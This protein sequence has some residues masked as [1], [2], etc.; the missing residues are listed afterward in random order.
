VE[1]VLLTLGEHGARAITASESIVQPGF[2]VDALDTTG[3]GDAFCAAVTRGL[4][5]REHLDDV[6]ALSGE[7][8]AHLLLS[9]Q[10]AGACVATTPG[11]VE[12]LTR[13]AYDELLAEQG[14]RVL[15]GTAD[16]PVTSR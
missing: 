11:C 1:L 2:S 8:L 16:R 9:G 13:S 6:G 12:G 3:C 5:E 10:A 15:D 7:A 14:D 4:L